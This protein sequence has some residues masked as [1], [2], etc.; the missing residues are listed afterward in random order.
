MNCAVG[1][2]GASTKNLRKNKNYKTLMQKLNRKLLSPTISAKTTIFTEKIITSPEFDAR[3]R[4]HQK[5]FT[6]Q[7]KL[8]LHVLIVFLINFARGSYYDELNKFFK[9]ISFLVTVEWADS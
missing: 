6:P 9:T 5:N 8:P 3:H 1:H 4:Q 7:R 2:R